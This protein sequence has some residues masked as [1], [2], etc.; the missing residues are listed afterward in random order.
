MKN[1]SL[2]RFLKAQEK[3]YDIALSEIK[4]GRKQSHWMWYI[5]P[6]YKRLG[7][8]ET[9][10]F[11]A[12]QSLDEATEF[13]NH[14][15]LGKRLREITTELLKLE[16]HNTYKIFG[17]PDDMKLKSCMT[18]FSLVDEDEKYIFKNVLDKFFNGENDEMTIQLT[19]K[20]ST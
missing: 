1:S 2:D 8:S 9:S 15:V 16:E 13:I 7:F 20:I 19:K 17:S 12:I 18:L 5:F 11:Y 3:V 4:S 6:Q 14:P 10:K